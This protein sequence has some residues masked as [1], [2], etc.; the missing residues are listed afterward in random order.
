MPKPD[1]ADN[2]I[3]KLRRQ[4]GVPAEQ[5]EKILDTYNEYKI[6]EDPTARQQL[7]EQ[8]RTMLPEEKAQ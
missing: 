6:T 4:T 8:L 2:L 1:D 7:L 3:L 5:R